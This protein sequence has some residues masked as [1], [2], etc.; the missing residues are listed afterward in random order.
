MIT[1]SKK[2][3]L[4]LLLVE[5]GEAASRSRAQSMILSGNVL[6]RNVPVT[7]A[8]AL[9]EDDSPI[10]VRGADHPYVSRGGLKLEAALDAFSLSPQ[11]FT[12]LDVGASTGGFT[13]VLLQRGAEKVFAVD[14]GH[15]QL[16]WKI[17]TNPRVISFEG[18]NARELRYSL[19]GEKVDF[20]VLDVSFIS[21]EKI[22]PSLLQFS[23]HDTHWISLIKPQFEVGRDQVG[24][25]GIVT[26]EDAR[27]KA[28]T[29]LTNFAENIGLDRINLIDSP[30]RGTQGNFEYL[31]YWRLK[32]SE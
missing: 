20:I 1:K 14:V 13:D 31:A 19:I 7:K 27:Q 3:R 22:L 8:G 18:V 12:G 23:H 4:D 9:I 25:G 6:V 11:G 17:R 28:V 10:R 21:L 16:D 15:N 29:R 2:K 26:S 5:K 32:K 24:K 30:I